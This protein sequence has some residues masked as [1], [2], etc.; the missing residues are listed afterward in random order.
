MLDN[1]YIRIQDLRSASKQAFDSISRSQVNI[2]DLE[3]TVSSSEENNVN[4]KEYTAP[5]KRQDGERRS[6]TA[7]EYNLET[8]RDFKVNDLDKD[9]YQVILEDLRPLTLS[10]DFVKD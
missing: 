4:Q 2:A 3:M 10:G 9:E 7:P 5:N 6:K 8:K 1:V